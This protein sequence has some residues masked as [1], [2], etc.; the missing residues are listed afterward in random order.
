MMPYQRAVL[1]FFG[2]LSGPARFPRRRR[3]LL[4]SALALAGCHRDDGANVSKAPADRSVACL[5]RISPRNGI[6]HLSQPASS[7]PG[8][9]P[10][11][12]IMVRE[13]EMVKAGQ[14]LAVLENQKRLETSWRAA[15]AQAKAAASRLA[16]AKAGANPADIEAQQAQ[17]DVL[18]LEL[19]GAK[20]NHARSVAL[21]HDTAISD[22]NFQASLLALETHEKMWESGVAKLKSLK[23]GWDL[24]LSLSEAQY[25]AAVAE[26]D[27]AKAEVEQALVRAPAD[28]EIV[29]I[30]T[31]PGERVDAD[32]IMEFAQI[33][34]LY[35][36]AE[37]DESDAGRVHVGQTAAISGSAFSGSLAGK[38]EQVGVKVG[39]N[40]LF[41]TDPA[42]SSDS[43]VVQ[44]WIRLDQA[45]PASAFLNA[46]VSVVLQP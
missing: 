34:P 41:S 11:A 37:V 15:A 20:V 42:A 17:V 23:G 1:R 3:F 24:D 4:L 32:G 38:V 26:A 9:S 29:R 35:V 25:E 27:H 31:W 10:V 30:S 39:R 22:A 44:V 7:Y 21:Q 43:R 18:A 6:V 16:E 13:G 28:G 5:G 12:A 45:G 14:I 2:G 8:V 40:G 19:E 36:L 33:D 46:R